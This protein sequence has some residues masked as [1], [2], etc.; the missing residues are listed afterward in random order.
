MQKKSRIG[1]YFIVSL[2]SVCILWIG[3]S[4]AQDYPKGPVQI[5]IPFSPGG[6]TDL[7]WRGISDHVAKSINGTVVLINK[8]GEG[9][10]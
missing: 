5:V 9:E 4:N 1:V 7:F 10:W 6:G 3:G 2:V 8:P